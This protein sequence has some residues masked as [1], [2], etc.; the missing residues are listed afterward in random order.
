MNFFY[1]DRLQKL[2]LTVSKGSTTAAIDLL[3]VDIIYSLPIEISLMDRSLRI[4]L[5][6]TECNSIRPQIVSAT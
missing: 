6:Q 2:M 4:S 3:G 1:Y 5:R